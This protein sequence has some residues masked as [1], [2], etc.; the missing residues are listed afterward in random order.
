MAAS[1][2]NDEP[3]HPPVRHN[4]LYAF[5]IQMCANAA[6]T[7]LAAAILYLYGVM[8]GLL[9]ANWRILGPTLV[10]LVGALSVSIF[11]F[12]YIAILH[13]KPASIIGNTWVFIL[14]MYVI[15]GSSIIL[16]A[17]VGRRAGWSLSWVLFL[18]A[19]LSTLGLVVTAF[20]L[21]RRYGRLPAEGGRRPPAGRP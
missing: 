20:G 8:A 7:L 15:F 11:E 1:L 5:V 18:W 3:P 14:L 10:L 19:I 17:Y 21:Q 4:S 9:Q 13:K 2:D 16:V 12:T 6:G